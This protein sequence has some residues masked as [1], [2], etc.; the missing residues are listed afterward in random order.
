MGD[1]RVLQKRGRRLRW[2]RACDEWGSRDVRCDPSR[3]E[4]ELEHLRKVYGLH[5]LKR[6]APHA[7]GFENRIR[8]WRN[9]LNVRDGTPRVFISRNCP[10]LIRE[11]R[12]LAYAEL[13]P[14]EMVLGK[15]APGCSDHAYDSGAYLLSAFDRAGADY[16]YRPKIIE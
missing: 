13:R 2:I 7:K 14:G 3:A 5:G 12:N 9:R 15:F 4:S 11:L 10:N 6:A 1:E 8:L 16:S